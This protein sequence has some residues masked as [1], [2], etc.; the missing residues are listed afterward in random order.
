MFSIKDELKSFKP[1]SINTYEVP[2]NDLND[3]LNM[4]QNKIDNIDKASKRNAISMQMIN[5]EIKEKNNE[6]L[7]L[8]NQL[9]DK[10]TE[11]SMF[12]KKILNI[13]DHM[14]NVHT[15]AIKSNNNELVNNIDSVMEIIKYDLLKIEFEEIP[16]IGTIFNPELHECVGTITDCEKKKYE[17]VDVIKKGYKFKQKIIRTADVIAVK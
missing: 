10:E 16:T 1:K 6:I 17:I 12:I 11:E 9:R 2:I 4:V 14:D 3:I 5:E 8:R 15:F 7:Q 13:L